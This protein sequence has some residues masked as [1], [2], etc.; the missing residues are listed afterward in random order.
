MKDIEPVR[1]AE[2][3]RL[4]RAAEIAGERKRALARL[5]PRAADCAAQPVVEGSARLLPDGA[6]DVIPPGVDYQFCDR[7]RDFL[8]A[9]NVVLTEYDVD[10]DK[11]AERRLTKANPSASLPTFEIAGRVYVGFDPW[12]LED[13]LRDAVPQSYSARAR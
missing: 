10:R 9:R 8:L 11:Q 5:V 3:R 6:G 13:A 1:G 7:A 4:G 12:G 2:R